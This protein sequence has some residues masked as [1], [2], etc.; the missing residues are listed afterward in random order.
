M[1]YFSLCGE[2]LINVLVIIYVPI[3]CVEIWS[4]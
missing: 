3:K 1:E 2:A 4:D